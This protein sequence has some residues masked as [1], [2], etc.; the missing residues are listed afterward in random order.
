MSCSRPSWVRSNSIRQTAQSLLKHLRAEQAK[1]VSSWP[2]VSDAELVTE[3]YAE[4]G[5]A[6]LCRRS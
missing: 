1:A 6:R 3:F 5:V 4:R 2:T